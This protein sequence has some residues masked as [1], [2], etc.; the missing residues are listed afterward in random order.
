MGDVLSG[1]VLSP[2]FDARRLWRGRARP[3]TEGVPD[4]VPTGWTPLD[5]ALPQGGWPAHALSEIL[6]PLDGVGELELVLPALATLATRERPA[7]VVAPPYLPGVDGWSAR[8]VDMRHVT[9]VRASRGS[10]ALWA[11]EQC[12]RSSACGAVLGWPGEAD[13]RALRR[14][15]VAA[16]SGHTPGFLFRDRR[17][18]AHA[19]P[20]ALRIELETQPQPQWR[21]RKCRGGQ[22][23]AQA[24]VL[25]RAG[26]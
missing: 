22:P 6:L 2:L 11:M 17:H 14:L 5:A 15:Q 12:L 20:A 4:G 10:D 19:S 18:A 26:A 23:P 25:A 24:F 1:A 8:G 3:A 16:E 9:I 21:V 13:E 7:M